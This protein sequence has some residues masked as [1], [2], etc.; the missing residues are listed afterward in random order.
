MK[1]KK[2]KKTEDENYVPK[3][4]RKDKKEQKKKSNKSKEDKEKKINKKAIKIIIIICILMVIG[5]GIYLGISTRRWKTLAK[6]MVAFQNST[7]LD[8][9]GKEIAKLGCSRKNTPIKL[10]DVQDNLKNAYIAIEDERFYKHGG[11]DVK[12]TGGAII[13]YV[14][15]FGKSSYGGSTITQ[16]LVKNITQDKESSGIDGVLRKVKEW[17]KAYQVEKELSKNQI[18]ELYLN[19][20]L[21]GGRNYGVQTGAE[22]YFN[23]DASNLSIAQCAFLAG[24]NNSPNRYNPY[25]ETDHTE[26][27]TKRTKTV[28]GQMK[29]LRIYKSRRI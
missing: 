26:L 11:I 8:S 4:F 19:L 2:K 9:D 7:V 14:I 12:R 22:Y 1:K 27:I 10:N 13:S 17:A 25:S 28:L 20:I 23:T 3:A 5:L 15:H 6:E 16:Q 21:V 24:I 29:K 18:L